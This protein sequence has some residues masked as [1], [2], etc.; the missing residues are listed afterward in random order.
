MYCELAWK[1]MDSARRDFG[2]E[3]LA[4]TFEKHPDGT[5][6]MCAR[7]P[8]VTFW[9][10]SRREFYGKPTHWLCELPVE[11]PKVD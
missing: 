7:S 5:T 2:Y 10:K 4:A 11:L 8:F 1:T 6:V 3:I 9:M